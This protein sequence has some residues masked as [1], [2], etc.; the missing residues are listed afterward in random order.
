MTRAEFQT[1][2][3]AAKLV[4]GEDELARRLGVSRREVEVWISG[5]VPPPPKIFLKAIDI[6]SE[7]TMA[8]LEIS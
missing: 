4:G 8:R 1:L 3:Y 2:E 6:V 5:D 7:A